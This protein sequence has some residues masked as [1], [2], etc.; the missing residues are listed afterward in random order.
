[1]SGTYGI[2]CQGEILPS[3]TSGVRAVGCCPSGYLTDLDFAGA[4]EKKNPWFFEIRDLLLDR[5]SGA[6]PGTGTSKDEVL[7][8]I[9][10][11]TE[12]SDSGNE[13]DKVSSPNWADDNMEEENGAIDVDKSTRKAGSS[14]ST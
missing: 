2:S 5:P 4:I 8:E 14:C 13:K 3:R 9:F 1:M 6:D 10:V 11:T 12:G 7:D